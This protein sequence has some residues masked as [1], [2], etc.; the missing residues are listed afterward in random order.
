[1][2]AQQISFSTGN[3]TFSGA[4]Y[5][6]IGASPA[7]AGSIR[8]PN[9]TAA[10]TARDQAGGGNVSGWKINATDDYEAA[11][12]VNLAGNTLYGATAANGNLVLSATAHATVTTAYVVPSNLFDASTEGLATR[13]KAGAVGDGEVSQTDVN[14]MIAIDST[15]GRLYFRYGAAWHYAAQTAGIQ[16]PADEIVDPDGYQMRPGDEIVAV[17]DRIMDDGALH[18]VWKLR[19]G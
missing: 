7:D 11:A 14:G 12:D 18:A 15:N 5:I 17:V 8:L 13:V 19:N 6:S 4:G 16:I 9:D 10:W 1:L 3:V 2:A